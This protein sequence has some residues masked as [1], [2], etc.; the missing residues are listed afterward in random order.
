MSDLESRAQRTRVSLPAHFTHAVVIEQVNVI[1]QM[2][3]AR[4]RRPDGGHEDVTIE[5]ADLEKALAEAV[6]G[7]LVGY[8]SSARP[9]GDKLNIGEDVS[10]H[11]GT[12]CGVDEIVDS[13]GAYLLVKEYAKELVASRARGRAQTTSSSRQ[14]LMQQARGLPKLT[15]HSH[16]LLRPRAPR[17]RGTSSLRQCMGVRHGSTSER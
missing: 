10:V 1:D 4:V 16:P 5:V 11:L 6:G 8:V 9:D 17:S 2:A 15:T 3:L 14:W 12:G 13:D 7:G